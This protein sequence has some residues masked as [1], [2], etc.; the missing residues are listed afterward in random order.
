LVHFF[1]TLTPAE[2]EEKRQALRAT[3]ESAFVAGV[4]LDALCRVL[5]DPEWAFADR[6]RSGS[7]EQHAG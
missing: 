3:P 1:Q 4:D 2:Y 7:V 5:S 6:T